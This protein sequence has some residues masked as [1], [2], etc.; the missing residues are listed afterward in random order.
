MKVDR[1]L[2]DNKVLANMSKGYQSRRLNI[3]IRKIV[4]MIF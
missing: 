3:G 1:K 4:Q 2:T